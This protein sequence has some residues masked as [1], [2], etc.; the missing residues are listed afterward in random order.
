M[1]SYIK[2]SCYIN[3]KNLLLLLMLLRSIICHVS[4]VI[5]LIM[6]QL[7][8]INILYCLYLK[9]KCNETN[10]SDESFDL[11]FFRLYVL[12]LR[13]ILDMYACMRQYYFCTGINF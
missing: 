2:F 3:P 7:L 9:L 5:F 11:V 1:I 12:M 6:L 13:I 4:D 10:K 8:K